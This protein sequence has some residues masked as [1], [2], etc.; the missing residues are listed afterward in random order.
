MHLLVGPEGVFFA[1][2]F[3]TYYFVATKRDCPFQMADL[4]SLFSLRQF[5]PHHTSLAVWYRINIHVGIIERT[6]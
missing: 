5:E 2:R 3:E 1:R 4:L 6:G